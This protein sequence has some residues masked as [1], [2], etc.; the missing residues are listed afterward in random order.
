VKR[1]KAA[2]EILTAVKAAGQ[3]LAIE[4]GGAK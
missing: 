1:F 4:N 2:V 3:C